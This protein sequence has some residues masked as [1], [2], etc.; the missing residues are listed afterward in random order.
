MFLAVFPSLV[1]LKNYKVRRNG[2]EWGTFLGQASEDRERL[3]GVRSRVA[4]ITGCRE[5]RVVPGRAKNSELPQ[6]WEG[7]EDI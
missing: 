5:S 6:P 4:P 2:K 1:Q 7:L 3:K